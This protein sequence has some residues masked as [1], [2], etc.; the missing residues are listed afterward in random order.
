MPSL[1]KGVTAFTNHRQGLHAPASQQARVGSE[2]GCDGPL[3]WPAFPQGLVSDLSGSGLENK[4]KEKVK[5]E[6]KKKENNNKN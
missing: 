2:Q 4:R 6:K 1:V 5:E 3:L